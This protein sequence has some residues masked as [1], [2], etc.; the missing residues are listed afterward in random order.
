M[1]VVIVFPNYGAAGSVGRHFGRN[2]QGQP[3][4][5]FQKAQQ[6]SVDG[7]TARIV[8]AI[9]S[10]NH[11]ADE[12]DVWVTKATVQFYIETNNKQQH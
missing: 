3:E 10:T 5:H 12:V 1:C 9:R 6:K 2:R 11:I 8:A 4:N 7:I